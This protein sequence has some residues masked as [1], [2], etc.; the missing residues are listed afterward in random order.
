MLLQ[1][2]GGIAL[3]AGELARAARVTP[4]TAS[5]HLARMVEGG[6]LIHESHGRH[7]YYRLASPEVGQAL[8]ALSEIARPKP[9]RSLRESDQLRGSSSP[10][11]ATISSPE[12][13][14]W[15]WRIACGRS[16]C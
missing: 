3:P 6:L 16:I 1:L 4:Q 14:G 8:E 13:S 2:L 9:V 7:R 15:C 10:G 11:C 5:A 12:R